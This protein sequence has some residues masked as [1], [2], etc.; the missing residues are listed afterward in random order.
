MSGQTSCIHMSLYLLI[1]NVDS[2]H[3]QLRLVYSGKLDQNTLPE[4][5][6][7]IMNR[8]ILKEIKR[9]ENKEKASHLSRFF[10]TGKG[11]Y[12][13]GDLFIGLNVPTTRMIAKSFYKTTQICELQELISNQFHEVRLC[14]LFMMVLKFQKTD[15]KEQKQ[16]YELYKGNIRYINNWDLVDLSAPQIVGRYL[17]KDPAEL[18]E[19]AQ[20]NHLWSQRI[21]IIATFYHIK[22]K[23]YQPTF[24]LS[25]Y[26]LTHKH[27][28]IHKATGWMLR[29][30][31]KRDINVLYDF[32]NKHN[33]TMPRTMLRYAIEKLSP[34]ERKFYMTK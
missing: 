17:Y 20:T 9:Y 28:L 8:D 12:A 4:Y 1:K 10:K 27:D 31:G 21:S 23:V 32:L 6:I 15:A 18:W 2:P 29:E 22:N 19:Y 25:E 24:E 26:F 14:A 34:E 5:N 16:I 33:K 11:Q 3:G 30:A 13:E 7:G